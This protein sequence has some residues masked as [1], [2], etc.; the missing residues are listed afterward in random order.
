VQENILTAV[1]RR[2]KTIT[3]CLVKLQYSA[4]SQLWNSSLSDSGYHVP[5]IKPD[6]CG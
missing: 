2:D 3:A 5:L 1:L 6:T 4:R